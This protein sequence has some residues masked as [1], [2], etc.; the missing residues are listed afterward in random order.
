M[1]FGGKEGYCV[2]DLTAGGVGVGIVVNEMVVA[3]CEGIGG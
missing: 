1:I 2:V 3:V